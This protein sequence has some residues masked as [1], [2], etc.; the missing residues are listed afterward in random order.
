MMVLRRLDILLEPTKEAVLKQKEQL[1]KMGITNQSPV[2]MTVTK[3]PFYNTSKF[4]M[5]TLT[6]ETNPMRLK[7]NTCWR[8]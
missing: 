4:T 7:M 6:S 3:Y 2:L 5:K 8:N 1:D